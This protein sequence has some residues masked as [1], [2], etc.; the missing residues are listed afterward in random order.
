MLG[1][2]LGATVG[3][4]TRDERKGGRKTRIEVVTEG[5]LTRRLQRDPSLPG[6]GLV[7]FD[8]VH[9][10][11]LQAD[12]GLAFVLDARPIVRPDL[13]VLAMSATLDAERFGALI[14]LAG[15][16]TEPAPVVTSEGRTFPI[17]VR[18]RPMPGSKTA[19]AVATLVREALSSEEGDVLA[20]LPG[21]ADI[22][23]TE[24][25]LKGPSR[26]AWVDVRPLFGALSLDEQDL[27]LLPSPEGRRKV[28][29]ATDI[30]E[31]SLTVEGV[32]VVVDGGQVRTP[33]HDVRTGLTRLRTGS[34]SKAAADQ[35]AGRAGRTEPGV[36]YR[37]WSEGE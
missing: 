18:W 23:R 1:E 5:I 22:R 16:G 29:L 31:T 32:R 25:A 20:F 6:I 19:D 8:E 15:E 28:V 21:A 34:C 26:P 7:V 3:L 36:A 35:R 2:D 30:A 27:A 4:Q 9:E 33:H 10:R 11:N 14:G 17:D 13:R 37:A 12:L 24:A